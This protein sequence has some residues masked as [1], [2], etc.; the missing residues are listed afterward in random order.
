MRNSFKI[1]LEMEKKVHWFSSKTQKINKIDNSQI[2]F[3]RS[4]PVAKTL[5]LIK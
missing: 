3:C 1:D 5:A 4:W 2:F